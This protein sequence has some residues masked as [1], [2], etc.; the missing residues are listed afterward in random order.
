VHKLAQ[1]TLRAAEAEGA[2][3]CAPRLSFYKCRRCRLNAPDPRAPLSRAFVPCSLCAWASRATNEA[4]RSGLPTDRTWCEMRHRDQCICQ[5]DTWNQVLVRCEVEG[6]DVAHRGDRSATG[7]QRSV[8]VR[9]RNWHDLA[10]AASGLGV[11]RTYT[12]QQ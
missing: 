10:L 6:F 8:K 7:L 9:V 11:D 2:R 4:P 3:W 12:Q 1:A 5:E